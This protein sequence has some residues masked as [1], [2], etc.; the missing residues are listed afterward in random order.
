MT[1]ILFSNSAVRV[2]ESY[3]KKKIDFVCRV[4]YLS[5]HIA[6]GIVSDII[7]AQFRRMDEKGIVLSV[8][9]P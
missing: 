3:A 1:W 7:T 5:F 4:K 8:H 9:F 6:L 2:Q